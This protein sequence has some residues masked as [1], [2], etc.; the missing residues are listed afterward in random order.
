MIFHETT[1]I[2]VS[3]KFMVLFKHFAVIWL[4]SLRLLDYFRKL[5]LKCCKIN[6]LVTQTCQQSIL[7]TKYLLKQFLNA[8]STFK[9]IRAEPKQLLKRKDK[10]KMR[11]LFSKKPEWKWIYESAENKI[12]YLKYFQPSQWRLFSPY[13]FMSSFYWENVALM[14]LSYV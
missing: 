11:N 10:T 5:K 6:N 3:Q 12:W 2:Q 13:S 4:G 9:H 8:H 14:Y 7:V 1:S